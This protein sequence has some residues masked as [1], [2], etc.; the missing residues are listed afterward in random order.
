MPDHELK[1]G[2]DTKKLDLVKGQDG[3]SMYQVVPMVPEYRNPL[4]YGQNNWIDGH[5]QYVRKT[6]SG[7]FEGQSIDTTHEGRVF[8]G[9]K[10]HT[11]NEDDDTT[12]HGATAHFKWFQATSE[13]LMATSQQIYRYINDDTGI[14]TDEALDTTETD[15]TM[16]ADAS[17]AMPVGSIIEIESEKCEV[18]ATG[19]TVTVIRGVHGSTAANHGTNK[20][21][22]IKKWTV[23]TSTV[24]S[25]S[26]LE[27][28]G[29]TMFAA[30]GSSNDYVYSTDGN[31]WTTSTLT[32]T[33]A[34]GF[35]SLPNAAGT[36]NVLWKWKAN[37][38]KSNTS[39]VNAGAEWSSAAY[40]GTAESDITNVFMINGQMLVGKTDGLYHYDTD[41]G[42]HHLRED[43]RTSRDTQNFK[44]L[45]NWQTAIYHSEVTGLGEITAY[46]SY[47]PMGPLYG[48]GDI[49]KVGTVVGLTSDKDFL[50][51]MMDEGTNTIIY[52]GTEVRTAQGHLVWQ[53]CPF[54]FLST[55][56]INTAN[57]ASPMRVV[58]H[59]SSDRRLWFQYGTSGGLRTA[60]VILSDNPTSDSSARFSSSGW[61]RMS[62]D[63]GSN[64]N[65]DKL[66]HSIIT[67]TKGCSTSGETVEIK[68]RKDTE[69]TATTVTGVIVRNGVRKTYFSNPID[70]KRIQFEAHFAQTGNTATPEL[71][72]FEARGVEKPETSRGYEVVYS[73]GKRILPF[74]TRQTEGLRD[75]LREAGEETSLIQ[76]RDLRYKG[77][78]PVWVTMEPGY[79]Q[80]IEVAHKRG[81]QPTMGIKCVFREVDY[82]I[83]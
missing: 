80:E 50:Y 10:I 52:K 71:L 66:W 83:E 26:C 49:G 78:K 13:L 39:G 19:T 79:P 37:E 82:P 17:S 2:K 36:A 48:I 51:V 32:D 5:G 31:A 55:V 23:A 3:S 34:V 58:Q 21:V 44:H 59:S 27:V 7:Y 20:D 76:F 65:H 33:N 16:D 75:W 35:K 56:P 63:Y 4:V 14:D 57:N 42:V 47:R 61:V 8:L 11:V 45:T 69:T 18:T 46:N 38:L 64:K 40:I 29:V 67:E 41:G 53:W 70:C 60:Y 24:A 6:A 54:V 68:Y 73:T 30:R 15:I 77:S 43:L 1:I 62:Y 25:T 81:G 72:H 22:F 28:Y 74:F 9:P 12:L